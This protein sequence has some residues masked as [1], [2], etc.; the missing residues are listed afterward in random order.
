MPSTLAMIHTVASL[1]APFGELARE[2]LPGVR[3]FH[4]ADEGLLARIIREET[5]TPAMC[6]RVVELASHAEADGADVVLLTCSA[7]SP[8]VNLAAPLVQ[9]PI[10]KVD[11]AM[12]DRALALGRRIAVFSTVPAT[13]ESVG[14]LVRSTAAAKGCEIEVTTDL[15]SSAMAAL[16]SGRRKEH[17]ELVRESLANLAERADVVLVAQAS[18]AQALRPEDK[19]VLT[20]RW[21][22]SPRLGMERLRAADARG[23]REE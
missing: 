13:L 23:S 4:V 18:A 22:T 7:M 3:V 14:G 8:A 16:R 11:Q 2:M 5:I 9:V 17:D 6:L 21:L 12:V 19:E 20:A 10:H 1:A 15:N